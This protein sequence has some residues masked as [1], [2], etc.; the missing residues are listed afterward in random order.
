[1]TT[2]ANGFTLTII[3]DGQTRWELLRPT[4]NL[5]TGTIV[6]PLFTDAADGQ[7]IKVTSTLQI[8][9]LT[10]NGNGATAVYGAP[11]VLAA[12]DFFTL[13]YNLLTLS[14]YRIS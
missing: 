9:A 8:A 10:V 12:E 5:A 6:L 14:W 4:G 11:L 7:E 2:P 13:R 1:M 3:S